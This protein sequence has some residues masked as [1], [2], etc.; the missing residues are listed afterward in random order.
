[1]SAEAL[2]LHYTLLPERMPPIP[3]AQRTPAQQQAAAHLGRGWRAGCLRA[4]NT[5]S[6]AAVATSTAA[7]A[8]LNQA[9]RWPT[10]SQERNA[11]PI[12]A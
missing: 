4:H 7:S 8:R 3:E 12:R 6:H 5:A 10:A 2:P 11:E 9:K 1:M